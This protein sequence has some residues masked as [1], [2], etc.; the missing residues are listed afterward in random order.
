MAL[1]I[2]A[3]YLRTLRRNE[4]IPAICKHQIQ[5]GGFLTLGGRGEAEQCRGSPSNKEGAA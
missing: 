1:E 2:L 4:P 3:W 5:R